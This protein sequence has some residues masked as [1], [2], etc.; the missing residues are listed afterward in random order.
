MK[1][2]FFDLRIFDSAPHSVQYSINNLALKTTVLHFKV[3][4]IF[5]FKDKLDLFLSFR[6]LGHIAFLLRLFYIY[7]TKINSV[8]E[9]QQN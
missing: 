4:E 3:C 8:V 7:Q 6:K 9:E 5:N 1:Y 2:E